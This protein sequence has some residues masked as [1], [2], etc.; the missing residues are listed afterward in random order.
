MV[1]LLLGKGA[2]VQIIDADG[3]TALTAAKKRG[4]AATITILQQ[5]GASG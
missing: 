5:A 4:D 1:R 3:F 2:D